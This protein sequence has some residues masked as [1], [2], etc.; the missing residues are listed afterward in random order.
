MIKPQEIMIAMGDDSYRPLLWKMMKYVPISKVEVQE[1]IS[2]G[3][4][5]IYEKHEEL[6]AWCL[7]LNNKFPK[8]YEP[9]EIVQEVAPRQLIMGFSE[10]PIKYKYMGVFQVGSGKH[11]ASICDGGVTR[12]LGTYDTANEAAMAY[13]DEAAPLGKPLNIIIGPL[14]KMIT[15]DG[16]VTEI[17]I[18]TYNE[19]KSILNK[20]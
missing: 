7:G 8:G 16:T 20:G 18:E 17:T 5:G 11:R 3:T 10:R 6:V 1:I 14:T 9:T 19:I 12:H 13:N 15:F 2:K 4:T